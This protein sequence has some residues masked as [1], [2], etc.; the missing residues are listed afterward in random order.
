MEYSKIKRIGFLIP[1]GFIFIILVPTT[2]AYLGR[3]F[4]SIYPLISIDYGIL[5]TIIGV[6]SGVIGFA[7]GIW[8]VAV[9]FTEGKGT[10]IPKVATRQLIVD[11]PY[12]YCRNPMAFGTILLYLGFAIFARSFF[13][14]IFVGLFALILITYIKKF[15]E[16]ELLQKFGDAYKQYKENTSFIIP[17]K[18]KNNNST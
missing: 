6:L 11:G 7:I 14:I 8:T 9:Q 17:R 10:P 18:R 15:E 12:A 1:A 4:D 3:Y 13:A 5:N 16:K 2:L